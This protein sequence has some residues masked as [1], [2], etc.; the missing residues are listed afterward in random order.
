MDDLRKDRR[1][2]F[3]QL[4]GDLKTHWEAVAKESENPE[5]VQEALEFSS[6]IQEVLA[7]LSQLITM[8]EA[9]FRNDTTPVWQRLKESRKR[10]AM[11]LD[12]S[13]E[14]AFV[15]SCRKQLA[16]LIGRNRL[17]FRRL[18]QSHCSKNAD[19][20]DAN[21]VLQDLY[22]DHKDPDD[23]LNE[24]YRAADFVIKPGDK[25]NTEI[26]AMAE[27]LADILGLALIGMLDLE[28]RKELFEKGVTDQLYF[29]IEENQ[30]IA[31]AMS[32][33]S[34]CDKCPSSGIGWDEKTQKFHI[35]QKT[36]LYSDHTS[37][38][39]WSSESW[40]QSLLKII[41]NL[42]L[43]D[44]ASKKHQDAHLSDDNIIQLNRRLRNLLKKGK[45]RYFVMSQEV[46]NDPLQREGLVS[47]LKYHLPYLFVFR[48]N[49]SGGVKIL[50]G[51]YGVSDLAGHCQDFSELL[52]EKIQ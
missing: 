36:I 12:V 1:E 10:E 23:F 25:K 28:A 5:V 52:Q 16:D 20:W 17:L 51:D 18:K 40:L 32:F 47:A 41:W 8:T 3:H 44:E 34:L 35:D 14:V 31:A 42:T 6:R 4:G 11:R 29:D 15:E 19:D 45:P 24:V 39:L 38:T 30:E 49:Q 13:D 21:Q 33:S 37:N 50:S 43:S 9:E 26:A 27:T 2:Y 46:S 22:P 7:D 48:I